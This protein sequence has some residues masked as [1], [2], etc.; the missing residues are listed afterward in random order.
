MT[1]SDIDFVSVRS[2]PVVG[3]RREL[4]VDRVARV[5]PVRD[6]VFW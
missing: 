1:V 4:I 3:K 2:N 5:G 6:D